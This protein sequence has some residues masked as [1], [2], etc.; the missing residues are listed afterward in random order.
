M[1]KNF[2]IYFFAVTLAVHLAGILLEN[3]AVR[4]FSKPFIVFALAGYFV[5]AV[6]RTV[7][8]KWVL[9]ALFFSWVGD[10]LL[11]FQ[12]KDEGFFLGGL[13]SFLLAHIF[14]IL[15]FHSIRVR[16]VITGKWWLLLIVAVYYAFLLFLLSNQL[17]G[18]EV[19]VKVYGA[20]ISFM[21]I[22]ALHLLWLRNKKA[23]GMLMAGAL[24][25]V[26][27]DSVLAID[28]FYQSFNGAG[29]VIMLTYGLAQFFI[30][31]G[32]VIYIS[33]MDKK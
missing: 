20:V 33:S 19:P 29:L 7:F 10:I 11:L 13:A 15:F 25:F 16:E 21:F 8:S 30:V 23:G 24:L 4:F 28:K 27:S 12:P 6:R 31:R 1:N 9:A 3:E 5:A 2:W 14:Y 22:L 26:I 18:M 17:G 32:A